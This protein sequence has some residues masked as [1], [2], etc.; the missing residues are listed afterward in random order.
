MPGW[1]SAPRSR[2]II[3]PELVEARS[4]VQGARP[5]TYAARMARVLVVEDDT[6]LRGVLAARARRGGLRRDAAVGS[7]ARAARADRA[8]AARRAR[9][10]TSACRT[11]TVATSA[12]RCARAASDARAVPH[13]PRCA[14]RTGSPGS[15]PA[16]TTTSRSRSRSPSSSRGCTRCCAAPARRRAS[17]S[18]GCGSIRSRM[19]RRVGDES[20]SAD[21][22]RVPAARA[23]VARP[24][25]AVRRREL[26]R[27]G[28]A[29]RRERA[30]QHARRVH[31]AAAAQAAS[32]ARTRPKIAT[33]HGV[34]YA[35]G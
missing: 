10:S 31:R 26:V 32:A 2:L 5:G 15:A 33:V 16:A 8:R 22:D 6:E 23:L 35:I 4:A 19:R 25:E 1:V 24:G 11:P 18:A 28:L 12:R 34:G 21:A 3:Q 20:R 14:R 7:G 13:R 29:A 9:S 17:R 30:R 27:S